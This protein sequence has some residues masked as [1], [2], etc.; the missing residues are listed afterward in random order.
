MTGCRPSRRSLGNSQASTTPPPSPPALITIGCRV[1]RH[2][3]GLAWACW[4][5]RAWSRRVCHCRIKGGAVVAHNCPG[6][7]GE[8]RGGMA[9]QIRQ[10]RT[11]GACAACRV[12]HSKRSNGDTRLMCC[13]CPARA[14]RLGGAMGSA[15]AV[16]QAAALRAVSLPIVIAWSPTAIG[17]ASGIEERVLA[18]RDVPQDVGPH[19]SAGYHCNG[20]WRHHHLCSRWVQRGGWKRR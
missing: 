14:I 3:N 1:G 15:R 19:V 2:I 7:A 17:G 18:N 13:E 6:E 10:T 8:H 11:I 9:C 20:V 12:L 5:Q 4:D 16:T